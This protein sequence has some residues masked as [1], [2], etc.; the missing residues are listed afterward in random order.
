MI[1]DDLK[2]Y[3]DSKINGLSYDFKLRIH[4]ALSWAKAVNEEERIDEKFVKLWISFNALYGAG[5]T[6][7]SDVS[8]F[9]ES[10]IGLD[11]KF[12]LKEK[13]LKMI[14]QIKNFFSIP[15]LYFDYWT[16]ENLD[17]ESREHKVE[18]LIER[19]KSKYNEF[20]IS[21]ND[22]NIILEEIFYLIYTLRNQIVHGSASYDSTDNKQ[23]KERC[24]EM[25]EA[26]LPDIIKLMI[27][28]PNYN[29]PEVKYKPIKN[30]AFIPNTK[31]EKEV[32]MDVSRWIREIDTNGQV[33]TPPLTKERRRLVYKILD[34]KGIYTWEK[35][36]PGKNL[37]GLI[38]KKK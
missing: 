17:R 3:Y 10:I 7:K 25:L 23:T 13:L 4:R 24:I 19:N 29:W 2:K 36:Y 34:S 20:I 16:D 14:N 12:V 37:E 15:E 32:A 6:D 31:E 35:Y 9:L 38:I 28:N 21:G 22:A 26:F 11:D 18:L 5:F 30:E 8:S 1:Y 27:D 33:K